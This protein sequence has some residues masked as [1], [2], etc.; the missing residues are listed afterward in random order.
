MSWVITIGLIFLALNIWT[1]RR[2]KN[3][4]QNMPE[5]PYSPDAIIKRLDLQG[6][7][8]TSFNDSCVA[9]LDEEKEEVH[10]FSLDEAELP[11]IFVYNHHFCKFKDILMSEVIIDSETVTSTAKGSQIGGAIVGGALLG[12]V[13]ILAGAFS[14]NTVSR[15]RIKGIDI[16]LTINNL[17]NPVYKINFLST[18]YPIGNIYK[19]GHK[20]NSEEYKNA[21]SEVEKWQ[22]MFEVILRNQE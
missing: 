19:N 15:D 5:D 16:K 4:L 18:F 17:S 14:G 3:E 7:R 1:Y 21:I 8:F 9:I 11:K 6:V 10:V 12:G 13:G 2:E 22:G 20:K